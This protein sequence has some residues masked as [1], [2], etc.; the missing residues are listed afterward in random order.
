M[1]RMWYHFRKN[2]YMLVVLT[3]LVGCVGSSSKGGGGADTASSGSDTAS[4]KYHVKVAGTS[5]AEEMLRAPRPQARDSSDMTGGKGVN[6]VSGDANPSDLL[7][8]PTLSESELFLQEGNAKFD[9][10]PRIPFL[11]GTYDQFYWDR[12]KPADSVC[13]LM[14]RSPLNV[15]E[16]YRKIFLD[17]WP[18]E[19]LLIHGQGPSGVLG[20]MDKP[21][22]ARWTVADGTLYLTS[23]F[24]FDDPPSVDT[25][26]GLPGKDFYRAMEKFVGARFRRN[27][28][29]ENTYAPVSV[30]GVIPAHWFSGSFDIREKR[31][32]K[33]SPGLTDWWEK[34]PVTRLNFR[35][36]K[37]VGTERVRPDSGRASSSVR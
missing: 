3:G 13:Y 22:M 27:E 37:L 30:Y 26:R 32:V 2:G 35:D 31:T 9:S 1:N 33:N 17:L 8:L 34:F 11:A 36:G 28:R 23:L 6:E 18:V 7:T 15:L 4:A 10:L 5:R 21:Y 16:G 29:A 19:Y 20:N 12:G 14:S 25:I 24:F